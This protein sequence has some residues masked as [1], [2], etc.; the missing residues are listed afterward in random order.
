VALLKTNAFTDVDATVRFRPISGNT[1]QAGGIIFRA[2][3]NDNYYLVRANA[4]EGNFGFYKTVDGNRQNLKSATVN[5][6]DP[7][8]W[9]SLRVIMK[10]NHLQAFLDNELFIDEHDTS[11]E[12]GYVGVW[13]KADSET[14]FD[15]LVIKGIKK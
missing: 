10:G 12:S 9:H 1:D 11:F 13:T 5:K 8:Q 14:D 6:P 15:D 2:A 7:K 3:D 4:L